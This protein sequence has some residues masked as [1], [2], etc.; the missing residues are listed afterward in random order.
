MIQLS[1]AKLPVTTS[2]SCVRITI[3]AAADADRLRH[4][5]QERHDELREVVAEHLAAVEP[6]RQ[7]VRLPAERV[8]HRLRLVVVV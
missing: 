4:E 8:R 1:H 2:Q 7:Q 6:P 3:A 5:E